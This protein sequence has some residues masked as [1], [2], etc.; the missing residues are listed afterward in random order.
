MHKINWQDDNDMFGRMYELTGNELFK[1][2]RNAVD[3]YDADFN[4][5]LSWGQLRSKR[6][7]IDQVQHLDLKLGTV[8]VCAGWYGTLGYM[9][10]DSKI[11]IECVRSFDIDPYCAPIADTLNRHW[12]KQDWRFKATTMDI[13]QLEY[14]MSYQTKKYDNS[15]IDMWEDPNTI[16]NTSCEHIENFTDW[17]RKIPTDKLCIL[18]TSNWRGRPDHINC[19]NSLEEFAEQTPMSN[20]LYQGN[21]VTPKYT[22]FMRIGYR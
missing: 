5:A 6:W 7:L 14:P 8:F 2:I 19:S 22:R 20:V 11:Q 17:Y 10:L 16:I 4:D 21:L 13:H 18:Q 3:H 9:L 15:T 12:V 1:N